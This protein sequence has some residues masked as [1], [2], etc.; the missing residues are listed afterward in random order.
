M[1][2]GEGGSGRTTNGLCTTDTPS[3]A[4]WALAMDLGIDMDSAIRALV[5]LLVTLDPLGLAPIFGALTGGMTPAL[6]RSV[7]VKAALIATVIL[8]AFAAFGDELLDVLG[9]E[10][11]AFRVAGGLLLFLIALEMVMEKREQRKADTAETAISQ[12]QATNIAAFPLAF[13]LL[14][15][16]GAIT[17]VILLSGRATTVADHV[18]VYAVTVIGLLACLTTFLLYGYVDRFIGATGRAVIT[19]LLGLLLAALAV[20]YVVDGALALI[21]GA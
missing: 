20:Q 6:R 2:N 8:F 13:P 5:T 15:G 1:P 16:P 3:S 18:T 7:A 4:D 19:R 17:A 11:A 9:I 12:D 14:A 10:L 21:R